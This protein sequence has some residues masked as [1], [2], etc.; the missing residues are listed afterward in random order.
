MASIIV[1]LDLP[2]PSEALDLVDRLGGAVDFYKVG[3]P[4]FTSGGPDVVRALRER[5]K[6]VF[7][8]LK[9]HDIPNTVSSAVRQAAA[10]DVQ[11]LTVHAAGGPSMLR[12]A[13][14]AADGSPLRILAVTVLT[15]LAASELEVVWAK[16]LRSLR[17]EVDRLASLAHE[18]GAHGVISSALE[19]ESIR[20]RFGAGFLVVTPGI[21]PAG[22]DTGDQSRIAT[23]AAA[24][25]SGAD[26]LVIGR[27]I[28]DAPD[29]VAAVEAI[30]GELAATTPAAR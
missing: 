1:A 28:I 24:A 30:L 16:E 17:E 23:P 20:R 14:T 4:L 19:A 27:P 25:R 6:G 5:G 22:A 7:L 15:S 10:L 13:R 9:L 8:D 18:S 11:L 2:T 12:A 29:P 26:Y 21:R 3:V